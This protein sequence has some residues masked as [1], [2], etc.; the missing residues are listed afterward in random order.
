MADKILS[1]EALEARR[2]RV[3]MLRTAAD[4][5]EKAGDKDR[6]VWLRVEANATENDPDFGDMQRVAE[7]AYNIENRITAES[8]K[9]GEN[10]LIAARAAEKALK[11]NSANAAEKSAEARK[12]RPWHSPA[13]EKATSILANG[14]LSAESL[15]TE[16]LKRPAPRGVEWPGHRTLAD[17]LREKWKELP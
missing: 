3:E 11:E 14:H 13:F 15:A 7:R 12:T 16:I 8:E 9:A 2:Q 5:H 1:K 4:G 6:A 10:A 17:F